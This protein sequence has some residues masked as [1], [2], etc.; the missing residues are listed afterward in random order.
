MPLAVDRGARAAPP[1]PATLEGTGARGSG[2]PH[3]PSVSTWLIKASTGSGEG[4]E[5]GTSCSPRESEGSRLHSRRSS[6]P[7]L[8][9][10]GL[11]S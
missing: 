10:A 2:E 9:W 6:P 7:G 11:G 5:E 8:P 3:Q 4:G 1:P